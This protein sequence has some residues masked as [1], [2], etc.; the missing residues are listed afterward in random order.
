MKTHNCRRHE[1]EMGFCGRHGSPLMHTDYDALLVC[2]VGGE[3]IKYERK[4]THG[5]FDDVYTVVKLGPADD[6]QTGGLSLVQDLPGAVSV[7]E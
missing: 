1:C 5:W 2:K 6:S 7:P 3:T 4:V